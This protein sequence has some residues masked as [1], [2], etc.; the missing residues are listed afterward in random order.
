MVAEVMGRHA[1]WIA[2][3]SGMAAGAHAI[4]V[5]ERRTSMNELAGWVQSAHARGRAPLVVVAEGF[6]F[7]GDEA[8][9]ST[10][11]NDTF[12]RPRLGGIGD[13]VAARIEQQTKIETRATLLGHIQRGGV[14]TAFDRVLATRFGMHA[15]DL[16]SAEAWGR[17][18]AL[19]GT[20]VDDVD[21]D[22]ALG[23][24]K[25]VSEARYLEA[26]RLFG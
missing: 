3:H 24:P 5:P 10:K 6:V 18:V 26:A 12:G 15:I 22:D 1:G 20:D 16:A 14:P 23:A 9:H 8:A 11:G 13:R 17:M 7:E 2:L 25:L 21:L 19:H 4:L